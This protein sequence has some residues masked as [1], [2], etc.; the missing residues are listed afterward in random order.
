[1]TDLEIPRLLRD[2][3]SGEPVAPSALEDALA[4]VLCGEADDVQVAGLLVALAS[5]PPLP[6]LLAAAARVR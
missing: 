3:L 4:P 5:R 2:L 6:A 1:M